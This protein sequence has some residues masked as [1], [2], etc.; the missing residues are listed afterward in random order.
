MKV[1]LINFSGNVGKSTLATNLLASRMNQPERFQIESLN[2][3]GDPEAL[4]IKGARFGQLVQSVLKA[5]DAIIDVGASNVEDFIDLM[6]QYEGSHEGFDYFLVPAV[7]EKKQQ[8]DSINT[9]K[10][11]LDI[12]VPPETIRV[13]FNKVGRDESPEEEFS[14]LVGYIASTESI[15]FVPDAIVYENEIFEMLAGSGKS[16]H[17]IMTD[18]VNYREMLRQT[19]DEAERDHCA[20]MVGMKMLGATA[21]KN[22]DSTFKTLFP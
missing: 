10:A 14:A 16:L 1:V 11:L 2:T 4:K 5:D 17:E 9:L 8:M 6:K 21:T 13:V 12:G 15:E 3:G 7:K 22:L 18:P 19:K 20:K